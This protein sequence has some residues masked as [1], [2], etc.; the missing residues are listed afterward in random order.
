MNH[1]KAITRTTWINTDWRH[2]TL[3]ASLTSQKCSLWAHC[4]RKLVVNLSKMER[5]T[6]ITMASSSITILC[7]SLSVKRPKMLQST[8]PHSPQ[9]LRLWKQTISYLENHKSTILRSKG[10]GSPPSRP[11]ITC[12][13]SS[14][15][16]S[17]NSEEIGAAADQPAPKW[18][19]PTHHSQIREQNKSSNTRASF[20][21]LLGPLIMPRSLLKHRQDL[22]TTL[23][24]TVME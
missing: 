8:N 9:S 11:S 15:E 13:S 10:K 16:G 1:N 4:N 20:T 17:I 23:S 18:L 21:T 22:I 24:S 2:Q 14:W 6:L 7:L 19:R 5:T 12:W 3:F